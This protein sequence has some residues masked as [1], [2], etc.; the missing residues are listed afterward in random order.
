MPDTGNVLP[1]DPL[2]GQGETI[3]AAVRVLKKGGVL[4][5]PTAGLYGMGADA[6][7]DRAVRRVFAIKGRPPHKPLL[8]LLSG[9]ADLDR[10]VR[11]VPEHAAPLLGLWPGGITL[12][13]EAKEGLPTPLTGGTGKIGVR[14][15]AHPVARAL[16]QCFGGPITGTS[17]NLS[18]RPAVADVARLD[19]A[20]GSRVDLVLHAGA[21]PGG[22]GST[23]VDA[24]C[25]P[26]R[27]LREGRV[28]KLAIDE[29]L[30]IGKDESRA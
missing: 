2:A 9:L 24:T 27:V 28:P 10:V 17:A 4:V 11:T 16:T 26:V 15:P 14:M 1:I 6:F 22:V 8:I 18:G 25:F 13:F 19:P 12:I 21:L 7:S 29:I 23:I 5:F 20:I 3:Q 30:G